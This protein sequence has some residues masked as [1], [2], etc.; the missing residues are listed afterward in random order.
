MFSMRYLLSADPFL[1]VDVRQAIAMGN[2]E[3]RDQLV[4]LGA[5]DCEAAELLD[6]R[7]DASPA[8]LDLRAASW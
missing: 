6:R 1:P 7:C 5:T 8:P 2:A 4:R 3:A